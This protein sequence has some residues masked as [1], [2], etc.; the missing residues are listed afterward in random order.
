MRRANQAVR[1]YAVLPATRAYYPQL[2]GTGHLHHVV[3]SLVSG[4]TVGATMAVVSGRRIASASSTIAVLCAGMQLAANEAR[5]VGSRISK[6]QTPTLEREPESDLAAA[7]APE[8]RPKAAEPRKSTLSSIWN[9]AVRNSPI[10]PLSDD[11]YIQRL[12]GREA[13]LVT[14]LAEVERNLQFYRAQLPK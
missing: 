5:I 3:P 2:E 9:M 11:E 7:P 1:E 13:E 8:P 6:T 14:E 4:A 12:R 10:Q